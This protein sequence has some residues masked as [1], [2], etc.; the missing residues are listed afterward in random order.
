MSITF[1]G[2][3]LTGDGLDHKKTFWVIGNGDNSFGG[4]FLEFFENF[5]QTFLDLTIN[6]PY[7]NSLLPRSRRKMNMEP[8][9]HLRGA[10]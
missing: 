8:S 5:L 7:R 9:P 10:Y 3:R 4:N 2:A 1:K 6:S